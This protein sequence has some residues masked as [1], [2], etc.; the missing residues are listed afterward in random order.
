VKL[1]RWHASPLAST[2]TAV[3]DA[4]PVEVPTDARPDARITAPSFH[5]VRTGA[6]AMRRRL[7]SA[8]VRIL[9]WVV[10]LLVV[11]G[12]AALLVQRRVLLGELHEEVD[13]ALVQE[14]EEIRVLA[15]GRDPR[16]SELFNGNVTAIFDTFLRRNIPHEGETLLAIVS[17]RPY[18]ETRGAYSLGADEELVAR[19]SG[20]TSTQRGKLSTPAGPVRYMAVPLASGSDTKGVFVVANFLETEYDEINRV[21]QVVVYGTVL[22]LA[23]GIAWVLAGRVLAPVR[24]VTETAKELTGTDLNRRIAVPDSEDEIAELARTFNLMLDRLEA[25]FRQQRDFLDD[26]GH[27]LRTPIT[28]IRG[29]LELEG[30]DEAE[31]RVT[32]AVIRDELDRMARMVDDLLVLARAEQP[33]FLDRTAFDLDL[34][35]GELFTKASA[36]AERDWR[37]VSTGHG[38]VVADRHRLTQA[39]VNLLDNAARHSAPPAPI[40]LGSEMRNGEVRL[41]VRDHGPGIRPGDRDRIF[42]RFARGNGGRGSGGTAG[43]GLAIVRAIADAH[44]GRVELDTWLEDGTTFTVV[45]PVG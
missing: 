33:D 1:L 11:A 7:A 23:I 20:L 36:L 2:P 32:R 22:V 41:W 37:L 3:L 38:I 34:L 25:A 24:E 6:R 4:P 8:R 40:E 10:L 39:M 35:T 19:W 42:E 12:A 13:S 31:R 28:I 18:L 15:A 27:E 30:L 29:H 14:V 5:G 26:A 17:G 45:V 43:L 21:T 9:A 44:G 16:T